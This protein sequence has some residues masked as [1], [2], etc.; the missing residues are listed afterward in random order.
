MS[1]NYNSQVFKSRRFFNVLFCF[2]I[3]YPI[4]IN[5]EMWPAVVV[6]LILIN[7]PLCAGES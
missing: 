5:K 2:L 3:L 4:A 7:I 1:V 6:F